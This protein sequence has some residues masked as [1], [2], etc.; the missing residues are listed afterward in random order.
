MQEARTYS[1]QVSEN[2][3]F[4]DMDATNSLGDAVRDLIRK[5]VDRLELDLANVSKKIGRNHAYLWQFLYRGV[6]RDLPE[7]EREKLAP[8]IGVEESQLRATT[9]PGATRK[10]AASPNA[11]GLTQAPIT[12]RVPAYGH[13]VGGKDG[14]FVLNGNKVADIIA[15]SSLQSVP[16]A[17]AVYVV[18]DSMAPRYFAGEAVFVNP[19][20]PVRRDDFV[21]A[22]IA[23]DE[24]GEAPLAYVKRFVSM[25]A[26]T[27]KLAQFN[28]KKMLEFPRSKVVSIHRI[29]MGGDG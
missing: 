19:R 20:L 13:P 14:Q 22:Q 2:A 27:L 26:K 9:V 1:P 17:Y 10:A 21:V 24:G 11:R 7:S 25:D 16:E 18:G 3:Y 5:Q 15:P 28:P 6:P 12:T 29:I 4:F 8:I 23:T